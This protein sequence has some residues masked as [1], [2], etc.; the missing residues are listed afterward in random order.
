MQGGRAQATAVA[1]SLGLLT[2]FPSWGRGPRTDDLLETRGPSVSSQCHHVLDSGSSL[3]IPPDSEL[4]LC[5]A[6]SV[7]VQTC[8]HVALATRTP[9]IV[10][11]PPYSVTTSQLITSTKIPCPNEAPFTGTRVTTCTCFFWGG[12]SS[13]RCRGSAHRSCF[14]VW[15]LLATY[16]GHPGHPSTLL[17]LAA[18]HGASSGHV[19][20]VSGRCCVSGIVLGP[21][22]DAGPVAFTTHLGEQ[23]MNE[24]LRHTMVLRDGWAHADSNGRKTGWVGAG[25]PRGPR[26]HLCPRRAVSALTSGV[27]RSWCT[28]G[29]P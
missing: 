23:T 15:S 12:H 14:L 13:V 18:S 20:C 16:P 21:G 24:D 4:C 2:T 22:Q 11:G 27:F 7:C 19:T 10:S 28:T 1:P 9:A 17:P 3:P 25:R 29:T 5:L 8:V 26:H 6:P